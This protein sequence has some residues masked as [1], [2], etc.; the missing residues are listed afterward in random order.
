MSNGILGSRYQEQPPDKPAETDSDTLV[1]PPRNT[2]DEVPVVPPL[3]SVPQPG[4]VPGLVQVALYIPDRQAPIIVTDIEFVL[5]R[6]TTGDRANIIDLTPYRAY[7]MGVS[8]H[9]A[10]ISQTPDGY[11][12]KDMGS[13]NGTWL[14]GSRLSPF[15]PY[16]LKDGDHL[17]LGRLSLTVR[18]SFIGTAPH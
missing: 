7:L 13:A 10:V 5:G 15:V 11:L 18:F 6:F 3:A 1:V 2:Q 17:E 9:H 4:M 12:I 16:V 8:R 14:N